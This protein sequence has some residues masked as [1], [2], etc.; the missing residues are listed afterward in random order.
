[1]KNIFSDWGLWSDCCKSSQKRTRTCAYDSENFTAAS[2]KE[3]KG[4]FGPVTCCA[5]LEVTASCGIDWNTVTLSGTYREK[6]LFE[7][8]YI[9]EKTTQDGNGNWWSLRRDS[10][11]NEWAFWYQGHQIEVGNV[12]FGSTI[13]N[14]ANGPGL[15]IFYGLL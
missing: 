2:L 14:C 5:L 12:A 7:G 4:C 1:M 9:Y 11:T 8:Y 3:Q 13:E 15:M 6:G 10:T